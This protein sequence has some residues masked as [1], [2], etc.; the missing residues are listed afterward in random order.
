MRTIRVNQRIDTAREN[1][2]AVLAKFPDIA[3]WSTGVTKS[4]A[5]SDATSGVGA[6]RH[7]DLAPMG[8]LEET[9]IEWNEPARMVVRID[10]A[11]NVPIAHGVATF[12]LE[13]ADNATDVAMEYDY[14][15]KYGILGRLMAS[16]MLD[17]QLTRGFT[18]LLRDL[19][20]A[21]RA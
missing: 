17:R 21:A 6:T 10:S 19:E 12:T 2:W 18:N 9:V 1:V 8:S 7:C 3:D 15:P 5:T 20:T 4:L 14:E 11:A 13:P 16:V